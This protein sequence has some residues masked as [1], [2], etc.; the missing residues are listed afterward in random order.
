MFDSVGGKG[1]KLRL[2]TAA[3][4][5]TSLTVLRESIFDIMLS[6]PRPIIT[7]LILYTDSV[8]RHLSSILRRVLQEGFQVVGLKLHMTWTSVNSILGSDVR[9]VAMHTLRCHI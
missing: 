6:G 9:R 4:E 5:S 7:I 8:I 2:T 3:A 1:R